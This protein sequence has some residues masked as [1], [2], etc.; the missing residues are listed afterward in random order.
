MNNQEV[1]LYTKNDGSVIGIVKCING[2]FGECQKI[3]YK[4]VKNAIR[5]QKLDEKHTEIFNVDKIAALKTKREIP[6]GGIAM[7]MASCTIINGSNSK[8]NSY[9]IETDNEIL[10]LELGIGFADIQKSIDYKNG[11]IVGHY[12]L[13]V[14]QTI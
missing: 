3:S 12:A 5:Y 6:M 14:I 7:I 10:L 11:K 8:G 9:A 4:S 13:T 1:K 2:V